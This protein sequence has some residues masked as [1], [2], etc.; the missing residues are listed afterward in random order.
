MS[1]TNLTEK[2]WQKFCAEKPDVNSDE[3]YQVW[4]F[5]NNSKMAKEL[6]K[7]ILRGK[8]KATASLAEVNKLKPETAPI[9]NGYSVVTDYEGNPQGVIQTTEIR[10]LPFTGVDAQFAFDE[11]EGDQT[12]EDWREGHWKYFTREAEEL[13][14]EFNEK[15]LVTCE[16]FKLLFPKTEE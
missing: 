8:K 3:P 1:K 12:L 15:S 7:L 10:I 6:V 14:V 4:Y 11:G 9:D 16:R 5:G 13:N 2:F